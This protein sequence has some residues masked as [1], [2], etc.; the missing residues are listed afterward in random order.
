M[1]YYLEIRLIDPAG[2]LLQPK[3]PEQPLEFPDSPP[4]PFLL[5]NGVPTQVASYEVLVPGWSI[6][7]RID[8]LSAY[9]PMKFPGHYSAEVQLSV[10]IFKQSDALPSD[11][12]FGDINNFE[13]LL[14]IN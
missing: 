1:I 11:L 7:Q 14:V 3:R 9:Y 12:C 13:L 10:M 6:T 8:D 2:R 5:C 4:L